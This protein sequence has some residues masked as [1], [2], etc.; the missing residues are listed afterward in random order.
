MDLSHLGLISP[1]LG[2]Y[3][4]PM[5]PPDRVDKFIREHTMAALG[6]GWGNAVQYGGKYPFVMMYYIGDQ[7]KYQSSVH[8]SW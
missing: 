6:R 4:T 8:T 7:R 5:I 2:P 3:L 1:S